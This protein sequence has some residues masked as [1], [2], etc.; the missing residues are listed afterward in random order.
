MNPLAAENVNYLWAQLLFAEW[1][2]LG[3]AHVVVCP[4]SRSSPLAIAAARVP[5]LR[6]AVVIDER[7]AGFVALGAAKASGLPAAVVTTSGTAVANLLPAAVE[8]S[9]SG[10][11]LLLVTADRPPELRECGAN[12]SIEQARIFGAF[13]RWSFE[14]AAPSVDVDPA[15]V[16]ST[17][18][19][20]FHRA[21][22]WP[23]GPVHLN[24]ALR[25][26]LAP[27]AGP[28]PSPGDRLRRW[29]DGSAPW[30]VE[31]RIRRASDA[32]PLDVRGRR[33]LV[34][35]G[36]G[37]DG[38]ESSRELPLVAD[39]TC[40]PAAS[41]PCADVLLAALADARLGALRARLTPDVAVRL[42]G[43]LASK[44]LGEFVALAPELVV[45]RAPARQDDRHAATRVGGLTSLAG[46]ADPDFAALWQAA[47]TVASRTVDRLLDGDG[48]LTEPWLAR[49]TA[50][51]MRRGPL[52]V[53]SSMP[54]RDVDMFWPGERARATQVIAN[55]GASGIDGTIST[56]VGVASA[57]QA[58][59][60]ALLGD[61]S[62]LHDLG[63]LANV[64]QPGAPI[65]VLV[66]NN[67]GGAIFHFLPIA[68]EKAAS[69][70]FER[71]F[72]TPHG[73][74]FEHAAA[75]F[76]LRYVRAATRAEALEAFATE[77]RQSRLLEFVTDRATN[78]DAH[79]AIQHAVADALAKEF[80]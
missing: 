75:M 62:A 53:G 72:G 46:D 69:P 80:A 5:S 32:P 61:L 30:R 41:I 43:P 79:R 16:V 54:V 31:S 58:P 17:A 77:P 35:A 48:A 76:G 22:A 18:N 39:V 73:L 56:A 33:V 21:T 25:E 55:R 63:G 74:S 60:T 47:S 9:M 65:D 78:V 12:Q 1:R 6:T 44:R 68:S 24:V 50:L 70:H 23:R 71:L 42:G 28:L 49:T 8:A 13:A 37:A 52:V 2:R 64:R 7:C 45:E 36:A 15:F 67:D 40:Q 11:P 14:M 4:G 20:A 59:T 29:A 10:T 3:V 57:L 19:E 66:V 38:P 27:T 26:P 34:V 51:R